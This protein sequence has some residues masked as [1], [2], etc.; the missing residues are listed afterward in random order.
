MRYPAIILASFLAC[1]CSDD[2]SNT[3]STSD[4]FSETELKMLNRRQILLGMP[5]DDAY[6]ES[7]IA[8]IRYLNKQDPK[9]PI[10]LFINSPGGAIPAVFPILEAIN[11]SESPVHTYG[12]N[13]VNGIA[14]WVLAAGEIGHRYILNEAYITIETTTA[15]GTDPARSEQFEKLNDRLASSL[16]K[17]SKLSKEEIL[18]ALTKGRVF[19]PSDAVDSKLVDSF[20]DP[21]QIK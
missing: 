5:I 1:G 10:S 19:K 3:E 17:T 4:K 13:N 9:S 14:L 2:P 6:S 21:A 18:D 16:E 11:Q 12:L 7:T 20:F 8:K 15:G